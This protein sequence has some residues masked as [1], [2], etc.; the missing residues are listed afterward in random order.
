MNKDEQYYSE[1]SKNYAVVTVCTPNFIPG[2]MVMIYSFIKYNKWYK[3]DYIIL[4]EKV[5]KE[6]R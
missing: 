4:V 3:G 5:T 6:L 2:T 1:Q